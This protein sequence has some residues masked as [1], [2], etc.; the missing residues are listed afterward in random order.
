MQ[1]GIKQMNF[2]ANHFGR[3]RSQLGSKCYRPERVKRQTPKD[4]THILLT[5]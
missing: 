2:D 1:E 5:Q 4:T 3:N